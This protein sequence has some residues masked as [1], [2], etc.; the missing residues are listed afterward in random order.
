MFHSILEH[1]QIQ[2]LIYN[3]GVPCQVL[4]IIVQIEMWTWVAFL[5]Y[6]YI[7]PVKT[8]ESISVMNIAILVEIV[9]YALSILAINP[10]WILAKLACVQND[11]KGSKC[12]VEHH[13]ST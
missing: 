8:K 4:V 13:Y 11:L 2:G 5:G 12:N 10:L 1:L 3:V 7:D 6:F 9:Q